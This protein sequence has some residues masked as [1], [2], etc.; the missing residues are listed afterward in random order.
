MKVRW[1][2]DD[3][4]SGKSR[5]QETL[6]DDEELNECLRYY[7]E[8]PPNFWRWTGSWGSDTAV[9]LKT[10]FAHEMRTAPSMALKSGTL[11]YDAYFVATE[12][13][14]TPVFS[15]DTCSGQIEDTGVNLVGAT[16]AMA[17]VVGGVISCA[18]EL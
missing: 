9:I 16:G 5:P 1:Q 15:S 17:S 8:I 7:Q 11:T 3:G 6:I 10:W 14:A 18:S 4:Y 12:P 2:V 13:A